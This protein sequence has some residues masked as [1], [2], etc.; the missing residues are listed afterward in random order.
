MA[1][2]EEAFAAGSRVRVRD[3]AE[4]RRFQRDRKW[5]HPLDDDRLGYAG[6][7]A[8]LSNRT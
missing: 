2:Y 7:T 1:A 5:H 6:Q 4:L 3:L 8:T